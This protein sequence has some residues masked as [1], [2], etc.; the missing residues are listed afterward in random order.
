[1]LASSSP[2]LRS[3]IQEIKTFVGCNPRL[4]CAWSP[5]FD[6]SIEVYALAGLHSLPVRV[7]TLVARL[8]NNSN[9]VL[10]RE[11]SMR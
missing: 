1:M 10:S 2:G 8:E 6:P 4:R 11:S 9:L 7:Q 3:D 5:G